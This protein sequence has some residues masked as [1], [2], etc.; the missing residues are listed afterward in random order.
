M[1]VL[2]IGFIEGMARFY[3]SRETWLRL[4]SSHGWRAMKASRER[5]E[6]AAA[7]KMPRY[8][9]VG[10]IIL[11]IVWVALKD[12][13]DKSW[14]EV[15]LDVLPYVLVSVGLLRVPSALRRV[16]KRMKE[17]ERAAGFDPD[18]PAGDGG[19]TAIAL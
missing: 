2:A 12:A 8:L 17:H 16:A 1:A 18:D 6:A 13:L 14:L 7:R 4:R 5:F 15:A 19:P 3:P 10:L 9:A 11:V